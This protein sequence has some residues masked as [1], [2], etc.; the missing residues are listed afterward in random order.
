MA[1]SVPYLTG[2]LTVNWG[3]GGIH[4]Y[5]WPLLAKFS[6]DNAQCPWLHEVSRPTPQRWAKILRR[7][8]ASVRGNLDLVYAIEDVDRENVT[9]DICHASSH[10][11]VANSLL[12]L[13]GKKGGKVNSGG[14]NSIGE[15]SVDGYCKRR[16]RPSVRNFACLDAD[17]A[18]AI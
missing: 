10:F 6:D 4:P 5:P 17:G 1:P 12:G 9:I 8:A 3:R 15:I 11:A 16:W 2:Y 13:F 14:L 18:W 7:D